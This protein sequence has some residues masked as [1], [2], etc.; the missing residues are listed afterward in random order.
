MYFIHCKVHAD[1]QDYLAKK[2]IPREVVRG[3]PG[4]LRYPNI[5]GFT[6]WISPNK[7]LF[8][9]E[10][11]PSVKF[12]TSSLVILKRWS[13]IIL[14]YSTGTIALVLVKRVRF[15]GLCQKGE[16]NSKRFEKLPRKG[17]KHVWTWV[18]AQSCYEWPQNDTLY[19]KVENTLWTKFSEFW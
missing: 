6:L 8:V 12:L 4:I 3:D 18:L 10:G 16:K 17:L 19:S 11:Y 15:L 5:S 13:A 2:I 7:F 9:N 14:G 1:F